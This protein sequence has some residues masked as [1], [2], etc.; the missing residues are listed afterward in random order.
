M[1]DFITY[2]RI[3]PRAP[4][5]ELCINRARG[6]SIIKYGANTFIVP[7]ESERD[8]I[9]LPK[10]AQAIEAGWLE[11]A[12]P[13]APPPVGGPWIDPNPKPAAKPK[14]RRRKKAKPKDE[15]PLVPEREPILLPSHFPPLPAPDPE[16]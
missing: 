15:A 16:D 7:S 3:D 6:R 8:F 2:K 5:G 1:A 12:T 13:G 14:R 10:I 9:S 11:R 4:E